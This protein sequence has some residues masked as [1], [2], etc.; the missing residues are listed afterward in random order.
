L[1]SRNQKTQHLD[2]PI[3]PW[4]VEISIRML[5][6]ESILNEGIHALGLGSPLAK[7]MIRIAVALF[8][9]C[10]LNTAALAI[11]WQGH[12]DWLEDS[13][14]ALELERHF[15]RRVAPLPQPRRRPE[16]QKREEVGAVP[17]NP[18]DPVPMLCAERKPKD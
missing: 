11:N 6:L 15:D 1:Y 4:A 13:P 14:P 16:C 5:H 17:E 12:E 18:Y 7:R 3:V 9:L 2:S 8:I 10:G